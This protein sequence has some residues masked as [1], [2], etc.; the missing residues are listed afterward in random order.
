[1]AAPGLAPKD[2]AYVDAH[3]LDTLMQSLMTELLTSKP[4]QPMRFMY[5]S[6]RERVKQAQGAAPSSA[7]KPRPPPSGPR[8]PQRASRP[9]L[10]R[11]PGSAAHSAGQPSKARRRPLPEGDLTDISDDLSLGAS[12]R[13]KEQE[14]ASLSQAQAPS[15]S[16]A[17]SDTPVKMG[18]SSQAG[19]TAGDRQR[20]ADKARSLLE[21]ED[22]LIEAE[23]REA[24]SG[25]G[26]GVLCRR[27][28]SLMQDGGDDSWGGSTAQQQTSSHTEESTRRASKRSET[29]PQPADMSVSEFLAASGKKPSHSADLLG[30]DDDDD[31][32]DL[33]ALTKRRASASATAQAP[34]DELLATWRTD[35]DIDEQGYEIAD[36]VLDDNLSVWS[37]AP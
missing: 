10:P 12:V 19:R 7:G 28:R 6:L 4:S 25:A 11:T 9:S 5:H 18:A 23:E 27:C 26:S 29:T 22:A 1:M 15:Q 8:T 31:G 21:D 14:Q 36:S 35:D 37:E 24:A 16:Q 13:E 32:V 34:D 30:D 3:D 2:K 20:A 33:L 17:S